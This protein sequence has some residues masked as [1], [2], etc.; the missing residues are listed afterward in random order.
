MDWL[1]WAHALPISL[2]L[3]LR[4]DPYSGEPVMAVFDNLLPDSESVRRQIAERV[5]AT[6][7]DAYSLLAKLGRDCVGALQLLP[8]GIEPGTPG[9]VQGHAA[10]TH[11]IARKL[12]ALAHSPLGVSEDEE[13]RISIA[14][15]QE[16]TA[17]LRWRNR[18][19]IPRGTTATTHILKPQIGRLPSRIVLSQS[20]ENEYLCLKLTKAFGLPSAEVA[21]EDF[22]DQRV[23][24]VERFDR[25]WSRGRK[26]LL[27]VPQEDCC[28][29][30]SVPPGLKYESDGG[31][32]MN[33]VLDLLQG[34]DES[35]SDRRSFL[36]AQ[37]IFWLLGATD[38]HAKN[39]SVFLHPGGRFGMTPLY[40]VMSA[41]PALDAHQFVMAFRSS[42]VPAA[43]AWIRIPNQLGIA[44]S[45]GVFEGFG[46]TTCRWRGA[47]C[48]QRGGTLQVAQELTQPMRWRRNEVG[49]ARPGASDPVLRTSCLSLHLL[50]TASG[51]EQSPVNTKRGRA[52]STSGGR[53]GPGRLENQ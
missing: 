47:V 23:L 27:R 28:Q 19:H 5:Q 21:I 41:Q 52:R 18:W 24:V 11:D 51:G 49:V 26:R 33:D 44:I 9:A 37:L 14:G 12:A 43:S 22:E 38:G 1:S 29:A 34:S 6:G 20:V 32:G 31:P 42:A 15:A 40:D 30:L 39:F 3:P 48:G 25:L 50:R 45:T 4:E 2:S 17:L 53:A 8:E 46:R 36:K 16:K 10:S 13:F 7:S 35:E